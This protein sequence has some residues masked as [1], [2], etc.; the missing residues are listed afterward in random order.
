MYFGGN[1]TEITLLK[2]C[3]STTFSVIKKDV[4]TELKFGIATEVDFAPITFWVIKQLLLQFEVTL[5]W[6]KVCSYVIPKLS[7]NDAFTLQGVSENNNAITKS[8]NRLL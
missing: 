7:N 5:L 4:R 3:F 6:F 2:T 1:F 8:S